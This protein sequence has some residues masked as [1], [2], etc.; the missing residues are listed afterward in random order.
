MFFRSL[1]MSGAVLALVGLAAA[2]ALPSADPVHTV[3]V[4]CDRGHTIAHALGA[5]DE[6]KPLVVQ[7][8]GTCTENVLVTR[9]DVTLQGPAA[10]VAA[11]VTLPVVTLDGAQRVVL[12]ALV[13]SGGVDGVRGLRGATYEL[14]RCTV[15]GNSRFGVLAAYSAS[16]VVDECT[17]SG[18]GPTT[19]SQPAGGGLI[20]ANGAQLVLT[21]STVANNRGAGVTGT[22]SSFL[23]VGQDFGGSSV[24]GP[25]TVSG[26]QG[27]GV[28]VSD[29]SS[30][31]VIAALVAGNGGHGIAVSGTSHAQ[32]GVGSS[33]AVAPNTIRD[34]ASHGVTVYQGSRAQIHGNLFDNSAHTPAGRIQSTGVRVEAAAATI[35]GNTIQFQGRYGIEVSNS[36]GARIG[37]DD[38]GG[39][40]GNTITDN[41]LEG[42]HVVGASSVWMYG[43]LVQRNSTSTQNRYGILAVEGST[44]RMIGRNVVSENGAGPQ[45]AGVF[46]RGGGLYAHRGD[47]AITPNSNE[48]SANA[49]AG[50]LAVEN[51]TV[52]LRDGTQVINNTGHGLHLVHGTRARLVDTTVS[53]NAATAIQLSFGATLRVAPPAGN[54]T[55]AGPVACFGPESY[56]SQMND[57]NPPMAFPPPPSPLPACSTF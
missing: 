23:R 30:G 14:L 13:L 15:T 46:L 38:R 37:L 45:A 12:E 8:Q 24:P 25:V 20:A 3:R 11:D 29:G 6:R 40:A 28:T 2:P 57:P 41:S 9:N 32:I 54:S 4:D 44:V 39:A 55:I 56:A 52:E 18:N 22:R 31:I 53:G 47:F 10:L 34:N 33:G 50:I 1:T 48:I 43:N 42:V 49:G 51:S 16:A 35:T 17:V 36:G 26:N 7:I 5:A 21:N 27:N 19:P